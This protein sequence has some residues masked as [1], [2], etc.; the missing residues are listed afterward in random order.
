MKKNDG[1]GEDKINKLVK[2]LRNYKFTQASNLLDIINEDFSVV[3]NK[4]QSTDSM[5]ACVAIIRFL[6]VLYG[7]GTEPNGN[8]RAFLCNIITI[9]EHEFDSYA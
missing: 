7:D 3:S 8:I 1:M 6:D 9:I 5:Y 4:Y 2:L